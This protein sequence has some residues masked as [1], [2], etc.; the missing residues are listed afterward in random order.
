MNGRTT[1][2]IR[3]GTSDFIRCVHFSQDQS[4]GNSRTCKGIG[5]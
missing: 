5:S 1:S 3:A 4:N 2:Y